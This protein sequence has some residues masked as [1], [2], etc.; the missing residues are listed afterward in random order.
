MKPYSLDLRER[1]LDALDAG[2]SSLKVAVRFGVS[3]AFVRKL[4]KRRAEYGH[5]E[6]FPP[7]GRSRLLSEKDEERLCWLALDHA[8]ATIPELRALSASELGLVMSI[9]TV[10]RRLR[11]M[12]MTRKKSR[13]GRPRWIGPMSKRSVAG[14]GAVVAARRQRPRVTILAG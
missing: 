14:G 11:E 7:P 4:R 10:G 2:Q 12:G 5:F 9:T 1:V 8:D 3:E 6:W 13:F